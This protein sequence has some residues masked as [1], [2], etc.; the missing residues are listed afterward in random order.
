MQFRPTLWPTLIT[1]PALAL[2]LYLGW[3]QVERLQ[4]KT[5]LI[6]ELQ[7]R[8]AAPTIPMPTDRRVAAEDLVFRTVTIT[9]RYIHVAEMRLGWWG[10]PARESGLGPFRLAGLAPRA[11]GRRSGG[12]GNR[13][14]QN[15]GNAKLADT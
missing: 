12:G 10:Y 1:V 8:A 4:W 7:I 3:W 2:L 6:A 9:G 13:C 5:D 11:S 15:P 14:C